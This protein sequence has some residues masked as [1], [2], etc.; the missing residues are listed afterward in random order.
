MSVTTGDVVLQVFTTTNP[1]TGAAADADSLPSGVLWVDGVA[2]AATVTIA[3]AAGTGRYTFS[4][5]MPTLTTSQRV[6]VIVTA[7]INAL[8]C[9]GVVWEDQAS[10]LATAAA[11]AVVGGIVDDILVDT[12]TTLPALI[13]IGV[14]PGSGT[15]YYTDTVDDGTSPLD[16][17]RVQLYTAP[18]RVGPAY[19]T[20]TNALG[21][22]EMWPDPGT[23]YR[24]LDYAGVSFAQDVE[25]V[26]TEP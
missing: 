11:L 12:G 13:A 19:E 18:D 14:G 3:D 25:V 16:G 5:T 9:A 15:G 24:W 21:V 1:S 22:F 2:N 17:V 10:P 6:Q 7:T 4:V 8:A 23:Y 20:Y 26:V